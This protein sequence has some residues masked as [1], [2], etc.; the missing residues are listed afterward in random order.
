MLVL[1]R[2]DDFLESWESENLQMDGNQVCYAVL[3]MTTIQKFPVL[4]RFALHESERSGSPTWLRVG[5]TRS[6][7]ARPMWPRAH[8]PT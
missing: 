8:H 4:A 2:K 3:I 6:P 1:R 7:S 5:N